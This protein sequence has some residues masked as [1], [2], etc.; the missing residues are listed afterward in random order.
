MILKPFIRYDLK[1]GDELMFADVECQ[2][3]IQ[4]DDVS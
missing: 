4:S 1:S 2:F 3:Y